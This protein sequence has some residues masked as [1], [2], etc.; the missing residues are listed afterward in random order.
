MSNWEGCVERECGDHRTTGRR[1]WCF[2]C[3]EWCYEAI[4][5][6]GCAVPILEAKVARAE[7][8]RLAVLH[9]RDVSYARYEDLGDDGYRMAALWLDGILVG[10]EPFTEEY[11]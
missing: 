4:P 6:K 7:A 3:T 9:V 1:A 5:C 8:L 2:D 11:Q 10:C